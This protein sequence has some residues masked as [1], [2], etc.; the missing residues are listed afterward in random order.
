MI[1]IQAEIQSWA[2]DKKLKGHE[3]DIRMFEAKTEYFKVEAQILEL[4]AKA[5]LEMAQAQAQQDNGK[6]KQYE[7]QLSILS[8]HLDAMRDAAKFMQDG[9]IHNNEMAQGQQQL[10]QQQQSIDNEKQANQQQ[11]D[12]GVAG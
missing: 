12:Q 2:E 8:E 4:K 5:M 9:Q 1:K 3:L 11:G 10:D 7:L 6:F